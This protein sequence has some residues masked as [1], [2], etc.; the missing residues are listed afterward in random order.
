MS[1]FD[2][3]LAIFCDGQVRG[4]VQRDSTLLHL[5]FSLDRVEKLGQEEGKK[6]KRRRRLIALRY[7]KGG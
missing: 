4:I 1:A 5:L 6:R 2:A 3:R 7:I